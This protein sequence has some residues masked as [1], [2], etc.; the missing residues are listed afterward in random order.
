M[1]DI[2]SLEKR[3]SNLE[4]Y[5]SLS[6]LE[7]DTKST[8]I[9]DATTGLD[10]FKNGFVVDDFTGHGVGDVKSPDYNVAVDKQNRTLR[11]AHFTDSLTIIENISN[12]TQRSTRGYTK[13]GDLLTLPYTQATLVSNPNATRSVD[14][15]PYKIG[16]YKVEV[17]LFPESSI[18]VSYTHLT[19]PTMMSV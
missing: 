19:L 1:R 12:T 13:T 16:A 3:I 11:P 15:N 5:T 2:G 14:V 18:S 9:K 4:Y 17:N 7:K 8:A 6:L 10:R